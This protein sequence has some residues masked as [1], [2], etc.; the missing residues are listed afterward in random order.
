[1]ALPSAAVT[2]SRPLAKSSR[3]TMVIDLEI[4]QLILSQEV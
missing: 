3:M 4:A 2:V 1:M